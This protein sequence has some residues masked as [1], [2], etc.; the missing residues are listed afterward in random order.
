MS[1]GLNSVVTLAAGLPL[2]RPA[3]VRANE[4]EDA[5]PG[6]GEMSVMGS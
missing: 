1:V 2:L 6:W 4:L 5:S 3:P